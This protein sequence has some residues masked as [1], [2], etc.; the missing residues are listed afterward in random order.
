MFLTFE[1]DQARDEF[2]RMVAQDNPLLYAKLRSA[3][4][5]PVI[6][7]RDFTAGEETW[8]RSKVGETTKVHSD[9]HFSPF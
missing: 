7:A 1:T 9:V 2:L 3:K 6:V 4:S 8:I 5:Q